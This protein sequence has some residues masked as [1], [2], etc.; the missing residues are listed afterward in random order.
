MEGHA[1]RTS[2]ELAGKQS[3]LSLLFSSSVGSD[4]WRWLSAHWSLACLALSCRSR[5]RG[6]RP[7]RRLRRQHSH[8]VT[9]SAKQGRPQ[10]PRSS[11]L[12]MD[13]PIKPGYYRVCAKHPAVH[14]GPTCRCRVP[15]S[16]LMQVSA[17]QSLK[18]TQ[19]STVGSAWGVRSHRLRSPSVFQALAHSR[20]AA[21]WFGGF[22][23]AAQG[24]HDRCGA[25]R[26]LSSDGQ[27]G[28]KVP[29]RCQGRRKW[30]K[31]KVSRSWK[32]PFTS[33]LYLRG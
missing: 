15:R 26:L 6:V 19:L 12:Y 20:A 23:H 33:R 10:R 14:P 7:C 9:L 22:D 3:T 17:G 13:G 31:S 28:G 25:T 29:K 1:Y 24:R 32:V 2:S 4:L 5:A 21:R 18:G 8:P 11:Y 16:G 30:H 27:D